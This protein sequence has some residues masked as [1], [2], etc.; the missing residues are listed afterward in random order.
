MVVALGLKG[1]EEGEEEE[2]CPPPTQSALLPPLPSVVQPPPQPLSRVPTLTLPRVMLPDSLPALTRPSLCDLSRE[3][4]PS[5]P[6]LSRV[7][8]P[9]LPVLGEGLVLSTAP[10]FGL[11]RPRDP[12]GW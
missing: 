12:Q 7:R 6:D 11:S 1:G 2:L 9:N 4:V 8:V 3:K 5:L 10:S